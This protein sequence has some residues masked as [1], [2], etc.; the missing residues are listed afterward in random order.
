MRSTNLVDWALS[1][2]A[3][4]SADGTN[5]WQECILPPPARTYYRLTATNQFE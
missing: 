4:R 1:G 3:E 2:L 5:V